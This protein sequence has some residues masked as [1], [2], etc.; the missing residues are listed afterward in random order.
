MR[1][2]WRRAGTQN[3]NIRYGQMTLALIAQTVLSQL[4][5]RLSEPFRDWEAGHF[6][7]AVLQGLDGDVR[8]TGDIVPARVIRTSDNSRPTILCN[9]GMGN[10]WIIMTTP[11]P[12][13]SPTTMPR[14]NSTYASILNI[15]PTDSPSRTLP[16]ESHGC[17]ISNSISAFVDDLRTSE[18]VLK[19][20]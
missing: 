12:S 9:K 15:C 19:I 2:G 14:T 16:P 4:R 20:R 17:M 5:Q 3:L 1:L 7:N 10:V 13:C 8:V 6:A 11:I 18:A